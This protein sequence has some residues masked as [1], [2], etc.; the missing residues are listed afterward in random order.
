M[1]PR[2][3]LTKSI[4]IF[5]IACSAFAADPAD[6]FQ[7]AMDRLAD[8]YNQEDFQGMTKDFSES[9]LKAL[10]PDKFIPSM[11]E[12]MNFRGKISKID[13]PKLTARDEAVFPVQFESSVMDVKI[14]LD[15]KGK[16]SGLMFLPHALPI[17]VPEKH[18]TILLLPFEGQWTVFW[19]G[20]T[21]ELNRHHDTPNQR[22][23]FDFLITNPHGKTYQGDGNKNED[24]FAFGR[25]VLAPADGVVTDVIEGVRDNQPRSMNPFSALGNAVMIEHRDHEISVLAHFKNGSITVKPGDKIK[26]GRLLGLCGNSGNS[27]EPHIHYHLQNTPIIQDGTGIK[28]YFE[29][30]VVTKTEKNTPQKHYSPV[31]GDVVSRNAK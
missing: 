30:V 8:A 12:M 21:K 17:P 5:S 11:R 2:V 16:V 31:K 29:N 10:P 18:E 1:R 24:Y 13:D 6:R 7:K 19:G 3:L 22:F 4:L 20:D 23:A 28:C 25:K 14:W 9:M 26:K 27:S 15:D